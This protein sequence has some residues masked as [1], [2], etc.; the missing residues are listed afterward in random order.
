M[1]FRRVNLGG[2]ES[3]NGEIQLYRGGINW[4]E[5]EENIDKVLAGGIIIYETK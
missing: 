3:F 1:D 2:G 5:L 4:S